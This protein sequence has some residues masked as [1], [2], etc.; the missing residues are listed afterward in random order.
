M[1]AW[2]DSESQ[3]G[4]RHAA[5]KQHLHNYLSSTDAAAVFPLQV[6]TDSSADIYLVYQS[7]EVL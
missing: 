1:P 3:T 4:Y 6:K 2:S 7:D 5:G